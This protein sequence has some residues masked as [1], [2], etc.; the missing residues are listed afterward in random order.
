MAL[1]LLKSGP[2]VTKI[3]LFCLFIRKE[4]EKGKKRMLLN[5]FFFVIIYSSGGATMSIMVEIFN[6]SSRSSAFVIG[7]CLNWVG[8][9]VI[10]MIFP[11]IVVSDF[12]QI[13]F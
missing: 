6:Q 11:F 2:E 8:L 12:I 5:F 10:G 13:S 1:R 3:T 9:F 7:G 4:M